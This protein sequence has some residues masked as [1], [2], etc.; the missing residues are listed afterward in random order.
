MQ[1]PSVLGSDESLARCLHQRDHFQPATY[2]VR[3]KAFEPP[4][5]LRLSVVRIYDLNTQEVW[6]YLQ[7]NVIDKMPQRRSLYGIADIKVS[8]VQA[9]GLT[10]DPD[11]IPPRH[12]SIVGWPQNKS[13]QKLLT[14]ELASKARLVLRTDHS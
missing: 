8:A 14:Q 13:E 10:V 1:L 7:I 3:P 4:A 11:N 12:A 2:S 9:T 5:D 6:A